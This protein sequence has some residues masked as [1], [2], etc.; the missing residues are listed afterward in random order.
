MSKVYKPLGKVSINL[1]EN[2]YLYHTAKFP[3]AITHI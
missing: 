3:D 1:K 2:Q